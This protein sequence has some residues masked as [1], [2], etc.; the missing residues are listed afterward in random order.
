VVPYTREDVAVAALALTQD[1]LARIRDTRDLCSALM[2]E[3][4]RRTHVA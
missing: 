4:A 3:Y 1:D 2:T